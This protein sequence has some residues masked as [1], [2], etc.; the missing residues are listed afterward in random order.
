MGVTQNIPKASPDDLMQHLPTTVYFSESPA[1]QLVKKRWNDP[2][3]RYGRVSE[4][5]LVYMLSKIP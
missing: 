4:C 2:P 5:P 1:Q 3:G